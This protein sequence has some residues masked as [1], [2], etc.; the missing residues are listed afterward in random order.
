MIH[1]FQPA[2]VILDPELPRKIHGWDIVH[3][4]R[5]GNCM[6]VPSHH[7]LLWLPEIKFRRWLE[8]SGNL[9][10]P[11]LHYEHFVEALKKSWDRRR[12]WIRA[13]SGITNDTGGYE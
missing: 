8:K 7:F 4:L 9:Q 12:L 3:A 11:D 10:K 6:H 5:S 13:F 2:V 1:Q